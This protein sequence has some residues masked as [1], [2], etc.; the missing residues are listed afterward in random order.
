MSTYSQYSLG[1]IRALDSPIVSFEV[2]L[3]VAMDRNISYH[4]MVPG[5]GWHGLS[6]PKKIP[7]E[8]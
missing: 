8:R 3:E 5:L 7:T 4:S 2:G 6:C 1:Q